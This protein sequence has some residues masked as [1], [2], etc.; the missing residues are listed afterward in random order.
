[1]KTSLLFSYTARTL[2]NSDTSCVHILHTKQFSMT[3]AGVLL[4]PSILMLSTWSQC[5]IPQVKVSVPGHHHPLQ[6]LVTVGD[7]GSP[8]YPRL[9]PDLAV[10]PWPPPS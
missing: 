6:V 2:S 5:Q 8:G 9:L 4:F 10:L 7:C 3:P 1:M